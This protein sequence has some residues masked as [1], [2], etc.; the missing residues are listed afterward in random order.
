MR[1][2][3]IWNNSFLQYCAVIIKQ[4]YGQQSDQKWRFF[5][6]K[7]CKCL[8]LAFFGTFWL[9]LGRQSG[10]SDGQ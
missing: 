4:F 1:E 7:Y 10:S 6:K 3:E 5:D 8:I 2:H 9:L